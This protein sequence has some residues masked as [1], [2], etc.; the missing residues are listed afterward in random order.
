V[1]AVLLAPMATTCACAEFI[2]SNVES[3]PTKGNPT[4]SI[5]KENRRLEALAHRLANR[6]ASGL[7]SGL[8]MNAS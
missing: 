4:T 3:N 2:A 5:D 1:P 6:L 8:V 7:A